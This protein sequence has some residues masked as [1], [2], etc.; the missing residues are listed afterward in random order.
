MDTK[1]Y[2]PAE[3][4]ILKDSKKKYKKKAIKLLNMNKTFANT[5]S[6]LKCIIPTWRL[7]ITCCKQILE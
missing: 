6:A 2:N 1:L 4:I 7:T 3:T 5:P